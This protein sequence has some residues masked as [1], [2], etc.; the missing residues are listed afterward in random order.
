MKLAMHKRTD[1]IYSLLHLPIDILAVTGAFILSYWIRGNG[2]ELYKLSFADYLHLVYVGVPIWILVFIVEGLYTSRYL[3][4]TLQ[5]LVKVLISVLTGWAAFVVY[6]TFLKTEQ[7]F[8]FPRLMLIYILVLGFLFVF[9]GRVLLRLFQLIMRSFGVGRRRVVLFGAGTEAEAINRIL[10]HQPDIGFNYI[11]HIAQATPEEL[12]QQLE[13]LK[14]DELIIEN[15][16]LTEDQVFQYIYTA[17]KNG[18]TCHLVPNT[19]EV[20]T[21]NVLFETLAGIPLLTFRQTPLEGWGRIL[22]RLVDIIVSLGALVIL[23]PFFL[24]IAICIKLTDGGPVFY[25][26]QRLGRGGKKIGVLKFR[27]LKVEYCVGPG[28]KAKSDEEVITDQLHR[29]D[30]VAEFN[31]EVKWTMGKDPR[32][33][34]IGN[35]LRKTNI[36]ELPQL[37]NVLRG[38]LSLVGP[39]PIIQSE[40]ERYGSFDTY[41][42]S[43]KPGMTG[44]WQVSG[45]NDIPY[46]E[47]VQLDTHYV[48]NWSL[49]QD[50]L[51]MIKTVLYTIFGV[52]RGY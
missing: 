42:L 19:F 9:S 35:F 32:V 14:I 3:F 38:E 8:V 51:I 39:R 52:S 24:L 50:F 15:H 13:H 28:F 41:L 45:R 2:L 5:N 10:R 20:Q 12:A 25:A 30:L 17:Q 22:K 16:N 7:T 23:S 21:S 46:E 6:L 1:L 34:R 26:H 29:P 31:K 37:I 48:Q 18:I 40:V 36:D 4:G 47:R 11:K 49:W 27:S 43:I 33:T 44:L